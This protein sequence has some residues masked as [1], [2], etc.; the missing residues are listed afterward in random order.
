MSSRV[1]LAPTN[2]RVASIN[3]EI[4]ERLE[5]NESK[6]FE[7]LRKKMKIYLSTDEVDKN[8]PDN[9]VEYTPEFLQQIR[10]SS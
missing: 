7:V 2:E 4:L 5:E 1:I 10:T 9:A 6:K 3:D 8:E